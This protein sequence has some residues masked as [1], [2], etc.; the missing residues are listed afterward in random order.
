[1]KNVL[2]VD[3]N[4]F[5]RTAIKKLLKTTYNNVTVFDTDSGSEALEILK[6]NPIAVLVTDIKMPLIN[7]IELIKRVRDLDDSLAILVI[8]GYDDFD[9]ARKLLP[10]HVENYLLKPV[11]ILELKDSLESVLSDKSV[12]GE[13]NSVVAQ[14]IDIVRN[15]YANNLTLEEI[16]ERVYLSP[17]Y[18]GV[19]FKKATD[20][21]FSH[22]LTDVRL[23]RAAELLANSNLRIANV[24]SFVG[25][26]DPSYF[27]KIFKKHYDMT[28]AAYRREKW[29]TSER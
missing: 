26:N 23:E 12:E 20:K 25:I 9:Y 8:S 4:R 14:V 29:E 5:E 1:M 2:L 22:Y 17:A 11:N 28:P 13:G 18:L 15:E 7:G 19:Q 10:Y 16:S 21:S 6:S 27:N 24:A 3:D